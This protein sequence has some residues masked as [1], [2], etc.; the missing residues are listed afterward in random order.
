[1]VKVFIDPGHGGSDSGAVGNGLLEKNLTLLIALRIER[2]LINYENVDIKLSRKSDQTVSLN[3]RT[4]L[5]NE[6]KADYLLSIHIN[7]GAGGLGYED[8]IFNGAVSS[9]TVALQQTMHVE[10]VK[11]L[12]DMV[13]RGMKRQNF[14][15]LR[16]SKMPALLTETGFISHPGD[17]MLLK[18]AD[19]LDRVALGHV[20]GIAKAFQLKR[21]VEP[22][23]ET[24][25][26]TPQNKAL[27]N[28]TRATLVKM[29]NAKSKPISPSWLEKLDN[30]QLTKDEAIGLLYTALN[31]GHFS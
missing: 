16:E 15:M 30:K 12:P 7:A 25:L 13:N 27:L 4:N 6:W 28:E 1:M 31:R 14:H 11:Q 21:K 19:F 24:T 3:T 8:F 22:L 10:V 29:M 2:L 17:A 5:A 9:R 23:N 20:N 18:R 26:Y